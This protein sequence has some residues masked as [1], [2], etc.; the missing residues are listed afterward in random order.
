MQL[1]VH[2]QDVSYQAESD[3][4]AL[5]RPHYARVDQEVRTPAAWAVRPPQATSASATLAEGK[6]SGCTSAEGNDAT[7]G[8]DGSSVPIATGLA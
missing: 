2:H 7:H 5:L 6:L 8:T 3:L 1:A 4:I